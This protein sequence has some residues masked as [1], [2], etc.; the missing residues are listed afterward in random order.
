MLIGLIILIPAIAFLVLTLQ[1]INRPAADEKTRKTRQ[2]ICAGA[3]VLSLIAIFGVS[4]GGESTQ[5]GFIGVC[6]LI[7]ACL[8][9]MALIFLVAALIDR[10]MGVNPRTHIAG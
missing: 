1:V 10:L 7:A 4:W 6:W 3:G 5:T 9:I 2:G 8:T